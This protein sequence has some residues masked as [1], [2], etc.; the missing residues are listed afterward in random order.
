MP[1][2]DHLWGT[3]GPWTLQNLLLQTLLVAV[4][5]FIWCWWHWHLRWPI[6]FA[7]LHRCTPWLA[8][9]P[10]R[11]YQL[12]FVL[13]HCCANVLV[14]RHAAD[15]LR[16]CQIMASLCLFQKWIQVSA[17]CSNHESLL[18]CSVLSDGMCFIISYFV[19][20]QI[21]LFQ[22]SCWSHICTWCNTSIKCA[23]YAV[24]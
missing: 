12:H 14:W 13:V 16:R 20:V 19:A 4:E 18:T 5:T 15:Y 24:V 10:S 17:L 6:F 8:G 11:L 22:S 3:F 23:L 1:P 9:C 2:F 21:Y 7:S